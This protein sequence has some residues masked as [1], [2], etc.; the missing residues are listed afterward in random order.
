MHDYNPIAFQLSQS[1]APICIHLLMNAV[2]ILL[3]IQG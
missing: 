2:F 3:N 1:S